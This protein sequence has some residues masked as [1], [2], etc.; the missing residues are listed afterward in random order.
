MSTTPNQ[1]GD[2]GTR[3]I[4]VT[5]HVWRQ[6]QGA[7]SGT[8]VAYERQTD[9][10]T[11]LLEVLDALNEDLV[12]AGDEP[13]AFESDCREG[14]CGTCGIVV[15]GRPHGPQPRTTTCQL[16]MSVFRDGDDIWLEPLRAGAFPVLKDLVVDRSALDRIIEAGGA[17]PAPVGA[18]PDGNTL[19]V[20]ADD[21]R[22]AFEYAACIGCGACVA[23]CPNGAAQL[24]AGA[25]LAHLALL[26]QGQ[27]GRSERA[28]AVAEV[29]DDM[30]GACSNH[31][32]CTRVCPK[33]IP[34]DVIGTF[35]R[36]V[37]GSSL[38]SRR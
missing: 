14:I 7:S 29:L 3:S 25:K 23:A 31:G 38:R 2:T 37:L 28:E 19:L 6:P 17:L 24:F 13:V 11:G 34:L 16:R 4:T 1:A 26:P 35:N 27:P 36:D 20:P 32:E 33:G 8:F 9:P 15:N 30:F 10:A 18:A 5:L 22:A 12:A 21:A